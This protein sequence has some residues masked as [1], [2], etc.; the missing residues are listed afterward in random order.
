MPRGRRFRGQGIALLCR[1]LPGL[2]PMPR[3]VWRAHVFPECTTRRR[4]NAQ[5][6]DRPTS[7]PD[8]VLG[9]VVGERPPRILALGLGLSVLNQVQPHGRRG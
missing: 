8:D 6:L 9:A 7:H 3:P 5:M 2:N 4:P 1:E